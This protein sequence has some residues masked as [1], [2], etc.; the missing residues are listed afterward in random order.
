MVWELEAE[1]NM[2]AVIAM[3]TQAKK[4]LK[5]FGVSMGEE[6]HRRPYVCHFP[7]DEVRSYMKQRQPLV[8]EHIAVLGADKIFLGCFH[9]GFL[10]YNLLQNVQLYRKFCTQSEI[11]PSPV[12]LVFLLQE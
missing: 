6:K 3:G 1:M 11:Y 12:E 8:L 5:A 2:P 7:C 10:I 4:E 9:Y